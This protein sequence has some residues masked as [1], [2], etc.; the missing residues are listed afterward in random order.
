MNVEAFKEPMSAL[1]LEAECAAVV[2]IEECGGSN[3]AR[4][5]ALHADVPGQTAR[6]QRAVIA[7]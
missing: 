1:C 7:L 2:I 4:T 3:L 6:P 5:A